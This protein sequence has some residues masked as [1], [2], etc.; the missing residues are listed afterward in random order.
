MRW[1][2][3]SELLRLVHREPGITRRTAG[4]QLGLSSGTLAETV[5]R[6]RD[7]SLLTETRA[8]AA[9][10]GRPTTILEPHPRGPLVVVVELRARDWA[11][12]SG[13]LAG[14]TT[15]V[16]SGAIGD[17]PPA[18]V[19]DEVATHVHDVLRASAGRV[20]AVVVAAAGTVSGTRLVQFT[21]RGWT[22]VELSVL[23]P[24]VTVLAGN[25]A[26]LGGFAEAWTGA[27]REHAVALH[28]M[29]TEGLGGVL[30]VD[31]QPV[32]GAR[33][34]GGEFGHLPFG[35]P[36]LAC[37]CG[38]HGC[39]GR[40]V[41][42][43]AL[44]RLAGHPRPTDPEGYA[45]ATLRTGER[46]AAVEDVA[47]ALG[48]GIAGLVN[49]HDPDVVTIAGLA[50]LVRA[51]APDAFARAYDRGL[52]LTNRDAPPPIRDSVHGDRGP[53]RG[54]LNLGFTHLTEPDALAEWA[55]EPARPAARG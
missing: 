33:G 27:A 8:A 53:A 1:A 31:G 13:D 30:L 25:D 2:T 42:G 52:M 35:D 34:R 22:D 18:R 14:H 39:W 4:E 12:S 45:R 19:L 43:E 21:V 40:T 5:G 44:A 16:A 10:P 47:G 54:A 15:P 49:A 51:A 50:P 17:E 46:S 23:A 20:R 7:A 41:D 32:R 11:V 29:V 3:A 36:R 37:P 38:A 9:G 28:L 48:A 55:A 24:E 26:T 6:L